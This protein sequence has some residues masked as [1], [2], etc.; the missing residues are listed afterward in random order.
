MVIQ[1]I[2][3]AT[4]N[5]VVGTEPPWEYYDTAVFPISYSQQTDLGRI[6]LRWAIGNEAGVATLEHR[7]INAAR[8]LQGA[9]ASSE[10]QMNVRSNTNRQDDFGTH[11]LNE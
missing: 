1:C 6:R 11:H 5:K 4:A 10:H 8:A 3:G 9:V 2:L 7:M